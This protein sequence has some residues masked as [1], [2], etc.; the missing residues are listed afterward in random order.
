MIFFTIPTW[1][2]LLS[3]ISL[4]TVPDFLPKLAY[5]S[6]FLEFAIL[7]PL[8]AAPLSSLS[9][10]WPTSTSLWSQFRHHPLLKAFC[11]SPSLS[12]IW[13]SWPSYISSHH[14]RWLFY[15][16]FS[17]YPV[18]S[19]LVR[20]SAFASPHQSSSVEYLDNQQMSVV[21]TKGTHCFLVYV[22]K[23]S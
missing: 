16:H 18:V 2:I 19:S 20:D 7:F 14:H 6:C 11:D 1:P 4:F 3:H 10:T 23:T 22:T 5:L 21:T 9:F 15:I 8:P 17:I 13:V 12:L